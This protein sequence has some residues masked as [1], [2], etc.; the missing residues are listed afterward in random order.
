MCAA[1]VHV[2]DAGTHLQ[3]QQHPIQN[4]TSDTDRILL[5]G[6]NGAIMVD[7]AKS[8]GKSEESCLCLYGMLDC[9]AF[10]MF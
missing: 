2:P 10:F 4:N 9:I 1:A 3:Q 7:C 6:V 5:Q 8:T